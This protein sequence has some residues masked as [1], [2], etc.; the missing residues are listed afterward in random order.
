MKKEISNS[1]FRKCCS[2]NKMGTTCAG[3]TAKIANYKML[4][5]LGQDVVNHAIVKPS[6]EL[7]GRNRYI[8][9]LSAKCSQRFDLTT[10]GTDVLLKL[11]DDTTLQPNEFCIIFH[12]ENTLGAKIHVPQN[13]QG[14]E[15]G[16]NTFYPYVLITS[17]FFLLLTIIIYTYYSDKLLNFYTRVVRHFTFVLMICFLLLAITKLWNRKLWDMNTNLAEKFPVLCEIL[18]KVIFSIFSIIHIILAFLQESFNTTHLCQLSPSWLWWVMKLCCNSSE[19]K[20]LMN[21]G[22]L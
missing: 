11:N 6:I 22:Y 3:D 14:G 10:N 17:S 2:G 18:G 7:S 4:T 12:Q 21:F 9:Q 20:T 13:D 1:I 16:T 15:S 19:L 8:H 5:K